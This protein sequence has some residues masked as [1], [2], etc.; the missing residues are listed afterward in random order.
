MPWKGVVLR[1]WTNVERTSCGDRITVHCCPEF[2]VQFDTKRKPWELPKGGVQP[3][4]DTA[5]VTPR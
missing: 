4:R 3:S 1:R 5:D 2:C